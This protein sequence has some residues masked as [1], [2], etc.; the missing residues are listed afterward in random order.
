MPSKVYIKPQLCKEFGISEKTLNHLNDLGMVTPDWKY[1]NGLQVVEL[2]DKDA[3]VLSYAKNCIYNNHAFKLPFQRFLWLRFIQMPLD[4]I[5]FELREKNLIDISRYDSKYLQRRYD[6]FRAGVPDILDGCLDKFR[7]PK[8]KEEKE[9]FNI[10]LDVAELRVAYENPQWDQ[11]FGFVN[12]SGVKTIVDACLSTTGTFEEVSGMLHELLGVDF[13]PEGLL[14][15]QQLMHDMSLLDSEDIKNYF[16]GINPSRKAELQ[17]AHGCSLGNYKLQSGLHTTLKSGEVVD[18]VMEQ[19]S[20]KMLEL[21]QDSNNMDSAEVYNTLRAF[22]ILSDR[23][24]KIVE[25]ANGSDNSELGD[26]LKQLKLKNNTPEESWIEIPE[27]YE[28]EKTP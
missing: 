16:K 11:A 21:V 5:E 12:D 28:S 22:N 13:P 6:Q 26:F 14:F 8:S 18:V 9:A 10:L 1:R 23:H 3:K 24:T 20:K 17:L 15:Y 27:E 2:S 7:P 25:V 4:L 19:V